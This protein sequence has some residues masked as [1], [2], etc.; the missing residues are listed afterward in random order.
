[1]ITACHSAVYVFLV[2]I[3]DHPSLAYNQVCPC[4][5]FLSL[6]LLIVLMLCL[7]LVICFT[8][9]QIR[10][11]FTN[12]TVHSPISSYQPFS[13]GLAPTNH[14]IDSKRML[15]CKFLQSHK[16]RIQYSEFQFSVYFSLRCFTFLF[17]IPSLEE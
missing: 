6:H 12:N 9:F 4:V 7:E 8:R 5:Y 17:L 14:I 10:V 11:C 13:I 2:A 16:L 15:S 1:M 3:Y